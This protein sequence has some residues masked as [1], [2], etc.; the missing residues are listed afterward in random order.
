MLLFDFSSAFDSDGTV[1]PLVASGSCS[2]TLHR[3]ADRWASLPAPQ[4]G[5]ATG[6]GEVG[7]E[8]EGVFAFPTLAPK[9]LLRTSSIRSVGLVLDGKTNV[10]SKSNG[11][12]ESRHAGRYFVAVSKFF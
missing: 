1:S 9:P 12:A 10:M 2:E 4:P 8:F 11:E 5:G 3:S 7:T 6:P